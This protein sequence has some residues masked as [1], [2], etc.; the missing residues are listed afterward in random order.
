MIFR[1]CLR[2]LEL[3]HIRIVRFALGFAWH[4]MI[5]RITTHWIHFYWRTLL[6]RLWDLPLIFDEE[7]SEAEH[8]AMDNIWALVQNS[9]YVFSQ[10]FQP[11]DIF[12]GA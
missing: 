2:W 11:Y 9:E 12:P 10:V 7:G 8:V 1:H 6:S 5:T 3:Q 4:Q